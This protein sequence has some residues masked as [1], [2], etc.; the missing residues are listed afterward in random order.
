MGKRN[1]SFLFFFSSLPWQ[2]KKKT[3]KGEKK[4][5]A[6]WIIAELMWGGKTRYLYSNKVRKKGCIRFSIFITTFLSTKKM[7]W[8]LHFV[9]QNSKHLFVKRN[10]NFFQLDKTCFNFATTHRWHKRTR[11]TIHRDAKGYF[12]T[13]TVFLFARNN[14]KK[15]SALKM[16][17]RK[18]K[19]NC[20]WSKW[21]KKINKM[22]FCSF[23][24][25]P[26]L[27]FLFNDFM[28][29]LYQF[30]KRKYS[31]YDFLFVKT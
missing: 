30:N 10:V 25:V 14:R 3:S 29:N 24:S 31:F 23:F 11:T 5:E 26:F 9:W 17:E 21:K 22:F 19:K 6:A 16:K 15:C 7:F 12:N 18:N 1:C 4:K 8:F 27:Y 20:F 13:S 2:K 28:T